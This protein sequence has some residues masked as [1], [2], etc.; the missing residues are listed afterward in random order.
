MI[1]LSI[2]H[3]LVETEPSFSNSHLNTDNN[4]WKSNSDDAQKESDKILPDSWGR[5]VGVGVSAVPADDVDGSYAKK[6]MVIR[7]EHGAVAISFNMEEIMPDEGAVTSAYFVEGNFSAE[8]NGGVYISGKWEPAISKDMSDRI[9]Y[10]VEDTCLRNIRNTTL[11]RWDWRDGNWSTVIDG[12]TF[13]MD[14]DTLLI[15]YNGELHTRLR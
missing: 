6:C 4:S 9:A 3:L 12:Y 14:G 5:I 13:D 10:F 8:Y 1:Q 11:A 15:S 7:C 2:Y